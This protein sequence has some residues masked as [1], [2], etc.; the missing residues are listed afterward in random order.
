[1]SRLLGAATF[2]VLIGNADAHGKNVALLHPSPDRVALAP[3]YDM[4]PTVFWPT[5]RKRAAR[6]TRQHSRQADRWRVGGPGDTGKPG[7]PTAGAT[8]MS[9]YATFV[10]GNTPRSSVAIRRDTGPPGWW[11]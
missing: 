7:A 6:R 8:A 10:G 5:L 11:P 9:K 1:M 2:T 4:V 3:L